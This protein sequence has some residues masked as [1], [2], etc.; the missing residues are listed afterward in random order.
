[1]KE[2]ECCRLLMLF[3]LD[4]GQ[5]NAIA[6]LNSAF[7]LCLYRLYV[8]FLFLFAEIFFVLIDVRIGNRAVLSRDGDPW[9]ILRRL[10]ENRCPEK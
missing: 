2:T 10:P 6:V 1:M 8:A 7:F 3:F 9:Y 5:L 4:L